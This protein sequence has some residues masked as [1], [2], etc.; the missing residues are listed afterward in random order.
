MLRVPPMTVQLRTVLARTEKLSSFPLHRWGSRDSARSS[1]T[2]LIPKLCLGRWSA[3]F[4][5]RHW[6]RSDC[7]EARGGDA[8]RTRSGR[9]NPA[10]R[11]PRTRILSALATTRS[12][13]VHCHF[14]F[15]LKR[16]SP[17]C[18]VAARGRAWCRLE[19]PRQC[20]TRSREDGI[21]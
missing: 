11:N 2:H 8:R 10:P 1:Q 17:V 12:S 13:R 9:P 5:S 6:R 16:G 14:P 19:T 7:P 21:F 20:R 3:F 15:L 4:P 18:T